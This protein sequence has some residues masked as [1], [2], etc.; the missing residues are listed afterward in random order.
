M[1]AFAPLNQIVWRDYTSITGGLD[2]NVPENKL[3][4]MPKNRRRRERETEPGGQ[5][6]AAAMANTLIAKE[7]SEGAA[8]ILMP[9]REMQGNVH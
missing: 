4:T 6:H 2:G 1:A 3:A 9:R 8:Q 7:G 5:Q